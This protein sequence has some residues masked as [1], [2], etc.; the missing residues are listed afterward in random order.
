MKP[1]SIFLWRL[2]PQHNGGTELKGQGFFLWAKIGKKSRMCQ[3]RCVNKKTPITIENISQ[4]LMKYIDATKWCNGKMKLKCQEG[5]VISSKRRVCSN[6]NAW[7]KFSPD[8]WWGKYQNRIGSRDC[9]VQALQH[10]N[11][12]K[13]SEG[14]CD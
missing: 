3:F 8:E 6:Y 13:G 9:T 11:Q 10:I 12:F 7:C 14:V 2:W 5:Y 4:F 1:F